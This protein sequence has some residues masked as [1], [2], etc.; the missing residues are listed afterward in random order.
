MT[1]DA[2]GARWHA[3][4]LAGC[5]GPEEP[6]ARAA[7]VS[8]KAFAD[9]AGQPM[10]AHVLAALAAVPRID[11]V[12][13]V[14]EPD[15]PALPEHAGLSVERLDAAPSPARSVLA[16]LDRLSG[17][18]L[19]TTADHPLLT[20]SMVEDLLAGAL[21]EDTDAAMAVA[22]RAVVEA[23]GNPAKRTY[24]RFRDA[25][26]SGCNLFALRTGRA[27]NAVHLWQR[28]EAQRKHPW[29]MARLLGL[30]SL[31]LYA[32]GLMTLAGA[33]RAL[34]RAAGCTAGFVLLDHPDAAHDVDKPA[35]L[36]FARARLAARQG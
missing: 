28:I 20:P 5:R 16:A 1:S 10:I 35:D 8:H 12:L 15:A 18:V 36:D 23:A 9:L 13:V 21:R 32:S 31:L 6:V 3:V 24:L 4:V 11:H 14:I 34:G 25:S 27:R 33:G 2:E 17:P 29:R 7:R 26:V 19:V 22:A 30:W